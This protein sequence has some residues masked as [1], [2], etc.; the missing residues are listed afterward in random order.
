MTSTPTATGTPTHT[1]TVTGTPTHTPTMTGTPPTATPTGTPMATPVH[2]AYLPLMAKALPTPTATLV[3]LAIRNGDFEQGHADWSEV[4][5]NGYAL[6]TVS[7]D[8][9][10]PPYAGDWVAWLGGLDNEISTLGQRV[11]VPV[12]D[13]Q[14]SFWMFMNSGDTCGYDWYQTI[15][16]GTVVDEFTL[17]DDAQTFSW[18]PRTLDLSAYAGRTV[19]L[20]L[21]VTTDDTWRSS[22]LIDNVAFGAG[23]GGWRQPRCSAAAGAWR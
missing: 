9:P 19:D 15:V 3:S 6:I 20:E 18:E 4:S 7:A 5:A 1:P 13:S 16:D 17:C 12:G 21:R 2:R 14:L 8:L 11:T 23:S 10:I 22:L